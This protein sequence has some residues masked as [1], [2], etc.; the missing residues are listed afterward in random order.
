MGAHHYSIIN[1]PSVLC[2]SPYCVTDHIAMT[3]PLPSLSPMS[4]QTAV[5]RSISQTWCLFTSGPSLYFGACSHINN[6]A[7]FHPTAF[8]LYA[9]GFAVF[10]MLSCVPQCSRV[11][12]TPSLPIFVFWILVSLPL[13]STSLL[14][15]TYFHCIWC[16]NADAKDV[17]S[18]RR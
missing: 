7:C 1:H 5:P 6:A 18:I 15:C 10:S 11:H 3:S 9:V 4:S 13:V 16:A 12:L 17:C 14:W 2:K 8:R